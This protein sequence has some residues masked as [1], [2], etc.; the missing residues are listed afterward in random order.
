M[1]V[2]ALPSRESWC[3]CY[4]RPHFRASVLRDLGGWDAFNVTEDADLGVRLAR[5][6]WRTARLATP[7][8]E[9][10]P[11]QPLAWLKQRTRWYKGWM[12]TYCVH[13]RQPLRL[14]R[15]LGPAGFLIVQIIL[16]LGLFSAL[17][18]PVFLA[19]L[20]ASLLGL[21]GADNAFGAAWGLVAI[22]SLTGFGAGYASA[23]LMWWEALRRRPVAG[24]WP[25]VALVPV[26]WLLLSIAAWR[27][28]FQFSLAPD[29]WEKTEHGLART[30]RSDTTESAEDRRQRRPA[31]ASG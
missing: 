29:L 23:A 30:S 27:A 20:I 15:G 3:V 6:G 16:G 4:L 2:G 17:A 22:L 19:L 31:P 7:T 21:T 25:F 18:H 1:R 12:Q 9:E 24:L 8:L 10:A 26:F 5:A 14:W 13:M 28:L 11:A